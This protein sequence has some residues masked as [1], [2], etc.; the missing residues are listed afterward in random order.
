MKGMSCAACAI[1]VESMLKSLPGV[2]NVAVN[3]AGN[4]A[5]VEYRPD[6]VTPAKMK[7]QVQSIGYD[8]Q[9]D[10][11]SQEQLE[12]EKEKEYQ[13]LKRK[14]ILA[15]VLS[16]PV[17][18]IAMVFENSIPHA[19]W[20]M[21]LLTLPVVFWF[22]RNFFINAGRQAK[23][24]SANMDT[25]VA[26][27]TGIAFFYS[28]FNTIFPNV[29]AVHG[30]HAQVYFESASVIVT[31]IL[32]G[33]LLEER[34]KSRASSAI[35]KLMGLQPKTV[36]VIRNGE[37]FDIRTEE[38]ETGD[39]IIIRPGEKIPVDGE[40]SEG[41]SFVDESMISGEPLAVEKITGSKVF[42]G[43]INQKGSL[44]LRALKVG[45]DTVLA[46]I[47]EAV[48]RA[49]GSKAPVQKL[50]DKIAGIFVPVVMAIAVTGF[51]A[52]Y[53]LGGENHLSMA[54]LSAIT[55]LI[56]A[57][58]CAL[59]LA[60]P[61]AI[62]VG[63]GKGAQQGILIKDAESLEKAYKINAVVLDKTGTI[64]L[65]QP[66]V[67]KLRWLKSAE[68]YGALLYAIESKSEHPL[69]T[70]VVEYIP[71]PASVPVLE[72]F[73]SVPGRGVTAQWNGNNFFVGNEKLMQ[74][75][76]IGIGAEAIDTVS[77]VVYF[78]GN[79]ELLAV[80]EIAD[81]IKEGSAKAIQQLKEMGIAVY[82]LTGDNVQSAS[83][84]AKEAGIDHFKA[85][86][87]PAEKAAFIKALQAKGDVVAMA[88]DGINDSEALALADV[89]IAMGKGT[90]IAMEVAKI[91]LMH[92]GLQEIPKAIHLSKA[93]LRT[94]R[95]NLFWAFIYN[96][97][98]IPI[99]A[100][101]L[102]PFFGFML[103]PMIA[104]AAMAMSSV[105]VVSNSLRLKSLKL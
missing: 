87:L 84:I 64:T 65:G 103:N 88:G 17:L 76:A 77:T 49:Q 55:V 43:T 48:K 27:S 104:G 42:A 44:Q 33:K 80:I 3:F 60:T 89:G 99:A 28:A 10:N 101:I 8:L 95:Q 58:P 21:M 56:I 23:H 24:F 98:G 4:T 19:D 63:V 85:E 97:I 5:S 69:A 79:K 90:D 37:E 73:S 14:T 83:A 93:T 18:L 74:E 102:Y 11:V 75:N 25:L 51:L 81:S 35:K 61:T 59:G 47:I 45:S 100:G 34:A 16:V 50:A 1:S 66:V 40:V 7:K 92:S 22:G 2:E 41:Y 6:E 86:M 57:C 105:S 29:L 91:T 53:F 20:I 26:L 96:I 39:H 15:A 36:K 12:L 67:K 68:Q 52:W 32:L 30:M 46:Q 72:Q 9:I 31:F 71:R 54:L 82:M 38:V 62:M 94:I 13:S 70:A 78:A